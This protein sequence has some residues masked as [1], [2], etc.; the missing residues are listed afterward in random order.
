MGEDAIDLL[1]AAIESPERLDDAAR[2]LRTALA[3]DA[4]LIRFVN[5]RTWRFPYTA[6][7]GQPPFTPDFFE[8]YDSA[9]A[10]IDAHSRVAMR[11]ALPHAHIYFCHEHYPVE[12]RREDPYFQFLKQFGI[13]WTAG[14]MAQLSDCE[15]VAVCAV[16]GTGQAPFGIRER[17][18]LYPIACRLGAWGKAFWFARR[19][20]AGA[21]A[22]RRALGLGA[23]DVLCVDDERRTLWRH[24]AADLRTVGLEHFGGRIRGVAPFAETRLAEAVARAIS[25]PSGPIETVQLSPDL[26]L[27]VCGDGGGREPHVAILLWGRRRSFA[28]APRSA[29]TKAERETLS[30]LTT[31]L[32]PD[33]IA[34]RRGVEISTVRTQIKRLYRKFSVH[35]LSQLLARVH[36]SL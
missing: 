23:C 35:S 33:E 4:V 8:A 27:D 3:A 5:T 18:R 10:K 15:A 9:F 36:A 21:R 34:Q 28:D 31:G 1:L 11:K 17:E 19:A 7:C 22:A 14:Y 30:L 32:S 24:G 2:M 16:R 26:N 20:E 12:A 13:Q 29:V 25:A 6:T